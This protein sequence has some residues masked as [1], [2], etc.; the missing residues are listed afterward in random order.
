MC[1]SFWNGDEV[2]CSMKKN[3]WNDARIF[4]VTPEGYIIEWVK[5]IRN[6]DELIPG[7]PAVPNYLFFFFIQFSS[8]N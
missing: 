3:L 6:R 5:Q 7:P 4:E 8:T 1:K 2:W